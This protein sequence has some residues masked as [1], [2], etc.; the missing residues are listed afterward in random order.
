[1]SSG[2]RRRTGRHKGRQLARPE[3]RLDDRKEAAAEEQEQVLCERRLGQEQVRRERRHVRALDTALIKEA[4]KERQQLPAVRELERV[5]KQLGK[6]MKAE[7]RR[8]F[9]LCA[10]DGARA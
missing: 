1:M 7:A 6:E 5:T 2:V 4:M 3:L 10:R 8:T 9:L